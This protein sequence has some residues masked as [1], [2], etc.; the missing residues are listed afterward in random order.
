MNRRWIIIIGILA[1][2][3]IG[4]VWFI[5]GKGKS[6]SK[7]APLPEPS[8]AEAARQQL[9]IGL[10]GMNATQVVLEQTEAGWLIQAETKAEKA[11]K[12]KVLKQAADIFSS[13]ARTQVQISSIDLLVR[14]NELKDAYGNTL[15][16]L[17]ILEITLS[18]ATFAKVDWDGFDPM[19]FSRIADYYWIHPEVE[20]TSQPS[21]GGPSSGGGS[22][23]GSSGSESGT[24]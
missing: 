24:K 4:V 11:E 19:N 12:D 21:E 8:P 23:G 17:P 10:E 7:L 6:N 1:V 9:S 5:Q 2:I 13:V 3:F 18:G 20:K 16:E 22:A 14:T 15:K